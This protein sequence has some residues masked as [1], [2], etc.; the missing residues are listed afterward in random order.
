MRFKLGKHK[1]D[2]KKIKNAL[3]FSNWMTDQT[4][5]PPGI[6]DSLSNVYSSLGI[7]DPKVLFPMDG[8]DQYGCCVMAMYGHG[9]TVYS[10]LIGQK[11]IPA[12]ADVI[13]AYFKLSGG[14]DNGLNMYD[15]LQY[16]AKN[17]LLGEKPPAFV[18]I[19]PSNELHVRLGIYLFGGLMT[20][21]QV[22]DQMESQFDARKPWD[23]SGTQI[24]GGHGI[25]T[26][27]YGPYKVLTWGDVQEVTDPCWANRVDE[28]Y[29]VLPQEAVANPAKFASAT[30]L[31]V[32]QMMADLQAIADQE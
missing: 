30:G 19:D 11:V 18:Y 6:F 8:N 15:T 26:G 28:C 9:K 4:I 10:G 31:S 7:S 14:Q 21:I 24:I 20:G 25:F 5:T 29:G 23:G 3:R 27:A 32:Q 16:A 2:P 17:G 22:D 13:N 12:A 1:F